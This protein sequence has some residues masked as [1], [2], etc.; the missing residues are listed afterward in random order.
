MKRRVSVRNPLWCAA[1]LKHVKECTCDVPHK[2]GTERGHIG[3]LLSHTSA[4]TDV[5][6]ALI[7][8]FGHDLLTAS[9][10]YDTPNPSFFGKTPRQANKDDVLTFLRTYRRK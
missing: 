9:M 1:C 5:E 8:A 7:A 10:W 3:A 2:R 4:P 6:E